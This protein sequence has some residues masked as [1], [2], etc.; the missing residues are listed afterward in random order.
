MYIHKNSYPLYFFFLFLVMLSCSED[1]LHTDPPGSDPIE[2]QL[3]ALIDARIG[4]DK[5]VGVSVS[6][7]QDGAE[8]WNLVGGVSREG[9][10]IVKEMKFGIASITKTAVAAATLK[11]VEQGKVTLEDPVSKFLDIENENIDPEIT[12]FQLLNHYSGLKGYFQ[13]P[14]IWPRV[15]SNLD[16]AIPSEELV[17]FIGEPNFRP[18]DRFEY[19]NSNYLLLGLII[20][21][22]SGKTVGEFMRE[23]FW[24]PLQ[25][26][27][28]FFGTDENVPGPMA[29]AWRDGDGDGVL[30]NIRDEFGPAYHS[31]FFTAADIF[32]TASDLSLWANHLYNGNALEPA[33]LDKMLDI[34]TI[35]SGSPY[36]NGYG[37]GVRRF[38]ISGRI[39]LGHTGG[40]RGYGSYMLYDP[41]S[42]ISV[43][44][45]NNQS[46]SENG[47]QLR[48]EL[49]Q[50]ILNLVFK[51]LSS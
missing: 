11:L 9:T 36:W 6:I 27:Q 32:T 34:V 33:S 15:E 14:E 30:E 12:V 45:L 25:L 3:Q 31:V 35:E 2:D 5:L 44:L 47:P 16:L 50:D 18:G 29:D 46:R 19:S 48:F 39:L 43:S 38:F 21:N 49:M 28:T 24:G 37:L 23:Q 20:K 4:S 8:K 13:H 7:R 17:N 22:V 42:G 26:R 40:M 41:S 51:E 1:N 10:P